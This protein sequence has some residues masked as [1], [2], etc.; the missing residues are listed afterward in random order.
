MA[1]V[2]P[3]AVAGAF[4]PDDA[5]K[6]RDL[7]ED[8]LQGASVPETNIRPIMIIVPHAGYIYSGAIAASGYRLLGAT[9]DVGRRVV[10]AGPS[11]FV[12]FSGLATP[13]VEALATPLGLVP[14]DQGLTAIAEANAVVD[15]APAAHAR[16]H[17]LE[18]QLPF[19]QVVLGEF[20]VLALATGDETP[21]AAAD[22][23]DEIIDPPEVVGVIS[24][25]LSHYLDYE[26][27]R[28][29]DAHTAEAITGLCPERLAREDACGRTA[30]QAALTLAR[31]RGWSCRL[32][33]LG[34]SGD[35]AGPRDRVVGYGAFAIGPE[36]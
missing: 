14:V 28:R 34:S 26:T 31:R 3:T 7:V 8:L 19:L 21:E 2:L 24:S 4:Y 29:Q 20:T 11:H 10:L 13:G 22:V 35:T 16:E 30:V 12:R 23:L 1:N 6:L 33:A 32:L 36:T 5:T 25:D 9:S 27:A 17:S 15:P 18:V